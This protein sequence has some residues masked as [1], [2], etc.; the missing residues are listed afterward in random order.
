MG[1]RGTN[2]STLI[3]YKSSSFLISIDFSSRF[4]CS[5]IK[6]STIQ[7]FEAELYEDM[8]QR[9]KGN[10]PERVYFNKGL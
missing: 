1:G 4:P 2:E 10:V 7:S 6:T 5:S 9:T 3:A 8:K